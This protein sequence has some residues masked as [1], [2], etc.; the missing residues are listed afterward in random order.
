MSDT[1]D[2]LKAW[3]WVLD[4]LEALPQKKLA[5]S[6]LKRTTLSL[7]GWRKSVSVTPCS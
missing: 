2:E 7:P 4:K 5:G 6:T 3:R 1:A